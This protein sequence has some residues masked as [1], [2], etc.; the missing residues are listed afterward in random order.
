MTTP[1]PAAPVAADACR[2]APTL[3][4]IESMPVAAIAALP[5]EAL[6]QLV[7][8]MIV[9]VEHSRRLQAIVGAALALRGAGVLAQ[10]KPAEERV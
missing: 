10:H 6:A 3:A 1:I 5:A 9:L 8:D 4:R 2:D 7:E